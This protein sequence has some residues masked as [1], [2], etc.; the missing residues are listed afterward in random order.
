MYAL[1][2]RWL[3]S[4]VEENEVDYM[5]NMENKVQT[6]GLLHDPPEAHKES[7]LELLEECINETT[8]GGRLSA[9]E[10]LV[11]LLQEIQYA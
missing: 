1:V 9:I 6:A 10:E 4:V 2:C 5:D 3:L 11:D 8:P 7:I